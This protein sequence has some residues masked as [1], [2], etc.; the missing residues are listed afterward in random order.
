MGRTVNPQTMQIVCW[1]C[2]RRPKKKGSTGLEPV[3]KVKKEGVYEERGLLA[4]RKRYKKP[5][6]RLP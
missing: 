5:L 6:L 4:R 1:C 3:S 2:A